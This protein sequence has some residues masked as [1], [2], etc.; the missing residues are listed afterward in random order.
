VG[1]RGASPNVDLSEAPPEISRKERKDHKEVAD[2]FHKLPEFQ[3]G[4]HY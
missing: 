4:A 2:S 3:L 1:D